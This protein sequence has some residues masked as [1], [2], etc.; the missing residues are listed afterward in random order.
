M[1][2]LIGLI[3]AW[4]ASWLAVTSAHGQG[5]VKFPASQPNEPRQIALR[6]E[7]YRPQG[8]GRFPA[9][10]LMHGCSGWQPAVMFAL[11]GYAESLQTRGYVVLNLDSF[12]P[13]YYSGDEMCA[14]N[15]RLQQALAY[16]TSDAFDAARYLRQ[17]PYVDG[18]NVFLMGQSNGGSVVIKAA[19]QSSYEAYRKSAGEPPFRG[20]V[21]FYPWCGL[22]TSGARF[23]TA[24]QIFSGGRDEWVS[25]RECTAVDATGA[26]Y[27]VTVYPEAAHSFD[28]D[29]IAQRYA[30]FRVGNDPAAAADSR[31]KM[32][33][34]LHHRLSGTQQASAR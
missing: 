24:V 16:R 10:I 28:L 2:L 30:G 8:S 9:V 22:L 27:H 15:A 13:R 29:I 5:I 21:A 23:A 32:I 26:E 6:G 7:L 25:A 4:G 20:A 19:L 11:R 1:R 14:S 34:F 33:A 3:S 17:L 31:K 12:G 18:D